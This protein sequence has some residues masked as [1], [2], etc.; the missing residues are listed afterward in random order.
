MVEQC[1]RKAKV[2]GST[3]PIGSKFMRT[4]YSRR[5]T[6]EEKKNIGKAV[7]FVLLTVVSIVLLIF[8]GIPL[9]AKFAGFFGDLKKS[10]SPVEISDITPPAPPSFKDLPEATNKTNLNLTGT[11]EPGATIILSYHGETKE[12]VTADNGVFLIAV[13]LQKGEN[14]FS[15]KSRDKAGNESQKEIAFT[16]LYSSEAPTLE[17]EYPDDGTKYYGEKQRQISIKG[18]TDS[19][20]NVT[21]NDKY[22]SVAD[23]GVFTYN[24]TLSEGF[25]SFNI[26][27]SDKAGN[28]SE[29]SITLEY[30][31]Y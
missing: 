29:K 1:F 11:S 9:L 17:I 25:N 6:V 15:A 21:V 26:K 20:V 27:A 19:G 30:A 10:S 3:P 8:L 16:I 7:K 5:A 22:V 18:K 12:V 24:T 13:A 2:G 31:A 23:D 14:K 4:Y 28:T